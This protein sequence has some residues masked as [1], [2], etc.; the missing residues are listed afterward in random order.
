M[1]EN[2]TVD[3][4]NLIAAISRELTRQGFKKATVTQLNAVIQA[5]NL[6]CDAI[7]NPDRPSQA[8]SGLE[9][10]LLS[11]D[12]G[13]SSLTMAFH[14][15]KALGW[16][17]TPVNIKLGTWTHGC[18]PGY[19]PSDPSDLRRCIGLLEA[20][21]DFK[22]VLPTI[23][24]VSPEWAA[25]VAAWDELKQLLEADR[26]NSKKSKLENYKCYPRMQE[27]LKGARKAQP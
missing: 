13:L 19:T 26:L 5:A 8:G 25:L 21:P 10:W 17:V 20:V 9:A 7:A 24:G 2:R 11:G 27:V 23:S 15:S 14:L 3:Q 12:T 18:T 16:D 4:I 1:A 6:V 22:P